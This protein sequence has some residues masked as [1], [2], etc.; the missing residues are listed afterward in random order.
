[1]TEIAVVTDMTQS[2][3]W[4]QMDTYKSL[5]QQYGTTIKGVYEVSQLYYQQGLQTA[6]VME[7]TEQTLI[8]AKISG[9]DYATATD[10]MTVA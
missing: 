6:E 3:L 8:M 2:D 5:A 1:M 10:Y 7:L 9:L 4:A